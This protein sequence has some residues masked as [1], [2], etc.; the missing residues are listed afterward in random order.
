MVGTFEHLALNVRDQKAVEEWYVA[1]MGFTVLGSNSAGASFLADSS[2][3]TFFELY[4][5]TDVPYFDAAATHSL[6]IHVAYECEDV[7]ATTQKL[8]QAGAREDI[9]FAVSPEGDKLVMLRDPFGIT[10]QLINR[11]NPFPT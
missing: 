2:G 9:P 8:L 4:S 6:T 5:R 1:N 11:A 10:I 3:R 7:E